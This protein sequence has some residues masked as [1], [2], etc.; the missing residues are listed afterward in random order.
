MILREASGIKYYQFSL[1]NRYPFL[2]HGFFS[3][4]GGCSRP[5]YHFLNVA[6]TVGDADRDVERNIDG[7]KKIARAKEIVSARQ[8]HGCNIIIIDKNC[9]KTYDRKNPPVADAMVT[10]LEGLA[11][12]IKVADCQALFLLDPVRRVVANVHSGW[13][14]NVKNIIGKT[15]S[16]MKSAFGTDPR[17]LV[18]TISPSLGPCCAEFRDYSTLLPPFFEKF[19]IKHNHFNFWEISRSQLLESGVAE[20]NIE[21]AGTCT[22]CNFKDFFSYRKEKVTGR[23]AAVVMLK[24]IR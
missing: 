15:V 5:P 7:I 23:C 9:L 10:A 1:L 11:L 17:D 14:G 19:K 13:R 18:A 6:F 16:V 12:M 20:P 21:L 2:F 22:V 4:H 24:N 8:E 3:R